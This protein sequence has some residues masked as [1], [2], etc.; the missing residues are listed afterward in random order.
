MTYSNHDFNNQHP[1]EWQQNE[2]A[3][4]AGSGTPQQREEVAESLRRS[5]GNMQERMSE[6]QNRLQ[7]I[8]VIGS[9]GGDMV[10]VEMNGHMEVVGLRISE[11][12]VDP[13]DIQ[14]LQDLIQAAL[15]D[16]LFKIKEKIREEVSSL[17][18]GLNLPPGLLGL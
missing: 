7:G 10:Q 18:G 12:A 2:A 9:A 13:N 8:S 16:A 4:I 5:F 3:V 6:I 11:E 14:M 15:S 1:D 17:T